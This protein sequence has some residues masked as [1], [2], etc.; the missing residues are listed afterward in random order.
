MT[1]ELKILH[2]LPWWKFDVFYRLS[3]LPAVDH[4]KVLPSSDIFLI[5]YIDISSETLDKQ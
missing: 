1:I 4:K 2:I 3:Y 5:T